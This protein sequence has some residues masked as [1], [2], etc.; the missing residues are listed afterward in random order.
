MAM[1]TQQSEQSHNEDKNQQKQ[2]PGRSEPRRDQGQQ[3]HPTQQPP[4]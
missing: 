2:K 1:Q 3:R 4:E